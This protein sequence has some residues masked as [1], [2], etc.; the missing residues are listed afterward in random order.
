MFGSKQAKQDRLGKLVET[1]GDREM[2]ATELAKALGVSD[3][4]MATFLRRHP[5]LHS[6]QVVSGGLAQ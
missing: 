5:R 4:A 6:R 3:H 2:G 1:L